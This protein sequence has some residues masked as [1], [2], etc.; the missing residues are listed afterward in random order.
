MLAANHYDK[1]YIDGCRARIDAQVAAFRDVVEAGSGP[2]LGAAVEAFEPRL[3]N[4]LVLQLD[5]SFVHRTRK[6]EGKDGNPLNEVRVVCNSLLNGDGVLVADPTIRL[7][8]ATSVLGLEVGG[9]IA[10]RDDDFARL[11][12]AFFARL[13]ATFGSSQPPRP[14]ARP[15]LT[16]SRRGRRSTPPFGRPRTRRAR[17]CR[18]TSRPTSARA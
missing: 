9:P 11:C 13:E 1:A 18:S 15:G 10:L 12:D 4:V 14:W 17:P 5:Y 16:G 3:F 2:E 8:P 6:M 7:D